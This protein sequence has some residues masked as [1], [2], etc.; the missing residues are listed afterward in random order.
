MP[1]SGSP[2]LR[3]LPPARANSQHRE[4]CQHRQ[5]R[6]H[7]LHRLHRLHRQAQQGFALPIA[8]GGAL[9]LLLSSSSLQLLALQNSAQVSRLQQRQQREDTLAAAAQ[10]QLAALQGAAAGCLLGVDG[11][12]WAQASSGC[13]LTEQQLAAL[14]QG[15]VGASHYRVLA[16]RLNASGAGGS[17]AE[18]ELQLSGQHPWRAAYRVQLAPAAEGGVQ[19]TALQELGLRGARA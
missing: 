2:L 11:T 13:G 1:R 6:Q 5:H 7:R 8:V 17:S 10:Q 9:L 12:A 3:G 4:Y 19:I 16:Y 18:L 14:Q 15:Q